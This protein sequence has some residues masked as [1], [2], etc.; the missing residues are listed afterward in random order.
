[1]GRQ[2]GTAPSNVETYDSEDVGLPLH[3]SRLAAE[4]QRRHRRRLGV[5]WSVVR[6][7]L[8][9]LVIVFAI[10]LVVVALVAMGTYVVH[11]FGPE[12]WHWLTDRQLARLPLL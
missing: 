4:G 3:H 8:S 10:G 11:L 7:L 9:L 5:T 2:Q 6:V 1:M 12:S